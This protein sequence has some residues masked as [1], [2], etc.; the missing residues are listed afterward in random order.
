MGSDDQFSCHGGTAPG[1]LT[2][3]VIHMFHNKITYVIEDLTLGLNTSLTCNGRYGISY[4]LL[5]CLFNTSSTPPTKK[6]SNLQLIGPLWP[7]STDD[8]LTKLEQKPDKNVNEK[9]L[10]GFPCWC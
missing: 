8:Q 4:R 10:I 7:K 9:V 1:V 5:D 6:T 2:R 3:I